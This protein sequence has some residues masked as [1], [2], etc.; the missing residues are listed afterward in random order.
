[1]PDENN[2]HFADLGK[3]TPQRRCEICGA[4]PWEFRVGD[5]DNMDEP[6]IQLCHCCNE[7]DK[8]LDAAF[9]MGL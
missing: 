2:G 8:G 5:P 1:M 4:L 3:P 7:D 9:P 6:S